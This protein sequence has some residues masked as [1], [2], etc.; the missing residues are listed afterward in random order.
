MEPTPARQTCDSKNEAPAATSQTAAA[1][2][3]QPLPRPIEPTPI[4]APASSEA[5]TRGSSA[6]KRI[7]EAQEHTPVID[8]DHEFESCNEGKKDAPILTVSAKPTVPAISKN[9]NPD[10]EISLSTYFSTEPAVEAV[11]GAAAKKRRVSAIPSR[12]SLAPISIHNDKLNQVAHHVE[13]AM[14]MV[15]QL[16][17]MRS[18]RSL[19]ASVGSDENRVSADTGMKSGISSLRSSRAHLENLK[20]FKG[21]SINEKIKQSV[22]P[23]RA[24]ATASDNRVTGP[25]GCAMA[26]DNDISDPVI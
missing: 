22:F 5:G 2:A 21:A 23:R 6:R 20:S 12:R 8:L 24:L 26:V 10:V 1:R 4:A 9:S 11:D 7:R 19:R 18:L 13:E 16:N 14:D 17:T 3:A 25:S 15:N